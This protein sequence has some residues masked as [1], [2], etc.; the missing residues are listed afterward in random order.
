[1]QNKH[2]KGKRGV[3]T[4]YGNYA[5]PK[6]IGLF[7]NPTKINIHKARKSLISQGNSKKNIFANSKNSMMESFK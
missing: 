2:K 3:K 7:A 5:Q 6:G 4:S 1:M